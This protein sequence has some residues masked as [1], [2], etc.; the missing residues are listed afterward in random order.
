MKQRAGRSTG[1]HEV[2]KTRKPIRLF[3]KHLQ[4]NIS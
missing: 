2:W 1:V 3:Q 4:F